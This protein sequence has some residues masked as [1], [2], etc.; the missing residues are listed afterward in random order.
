MDG[1]EAVLTCTVVGYPLPNISWYK[2]EME[3]SLAKIKPHK[4]QF[5]RI[6][7]STVILNHTTVMSSLKVNKSVTFLADEYVCVA[8]NSLGSVKRTATLT[9]NGKLSI[10]HTRKCII[11]IYACPYAYS[12]SCMVTSVK[13]THCS[14][15]TA[16][17]LPKLC[18]CCIGMLS[19]KIA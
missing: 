16:V 8:T 4:E 19:G 17:I 7:N 2:R 3:V 15:N 12:F 9:I 5:K 6:I 11:A 13:I 18:N 10:M 1:D 14:F